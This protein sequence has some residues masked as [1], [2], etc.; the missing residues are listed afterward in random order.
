MPDTLR[1]HA[2]RDGPL[3][4]TATAQ[5][6]RLATEPRLGPDVNAVA[7]ALVIA[8]MVLGFAW[9][10]WPSS[11]D[12][13]NAITVGSNGI[14]SAMLWLYDNWSGRLVTSLL[15]YV[16]VSVLGIPELRIV[17]TIVA[18]AFLL[19]PWQL[20]R[21]AQPLG[22]PLSVPMFGLVLVALVVGLE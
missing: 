18:A 14:L 3:P 21:L 2:A 20:T 11:D 9:Q 7:T 16:A 15:L 22:S 12:Y 1:T 8:V 4:V 17:S 19:V 5:E 13:C 10:N 6:A